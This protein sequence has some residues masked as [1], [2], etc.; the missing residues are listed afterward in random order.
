MFGQKILVTG[1]NGFLGSWITRE[2]HRLGH[3][4]IAYVRKGSDISELAGVPCDFRYGDITD[5]QATIGAAQGCDSV[6]HLAGLVS[7]KR[8]E[9]SLM[10]KVNVE[11]TANILEA[12]QRNKVRR[13]VHFSSVVAVGAGF[14][15]D[16]VLDENSKYNV[17][18]LGMGYF[19]TKH[20]A[21]ILVKR[22]CT[23]GRVDAVILNPST[24]YGAG[25]ARKGSRKMQILAAQG[26]L[27]FY[28]P[29]GVNVV[30]VEDLVQ[31]A[32]AAWQKGRTGERYI[33]CG[34]NLRI[35]EVFEIICKC[36]ES[37]PPTIPLPTVVLKTLG[38]FGD[39]IGRGFSMDNAYT[40]SLFHYFSCK[41]AHDE[42]GFSPRPAR[43]AIENSV[44]W[45]K[46]N[47]LLDT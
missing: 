30:A 35:K 26:K 2:L 4:P 34:E 17:E 28:P 29:G 12:V 23:E 19:N 27:P 43:V 47:K 41:K 10:Q 11:G 39:L 3:S 38:S 18:A 6:F 40:A 9:L 15:A 5:Q 42:L 16:Q 24:V 36:A 33:L 14:S 44:R 45:M 13:L 25:D 21:E 32:L 7:Y 1:A 8:K 37:Q 20:D 22:A 31:G 46:E